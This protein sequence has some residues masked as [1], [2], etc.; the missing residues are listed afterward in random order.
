MMLE[1]R[2][3]LNT[4]CSAFQLCSQ[5]PS[6]V[7]TEIINKVTDFAVTGLRTLVFGIRRVE[8]GRYQELLLELARAQCQWG[9]GGARAV[10]AA[11][12]NIET[13]NQLV[14][15]SAVEDKLQ[16]GVRKCLRSLISAGIQVSPAIKL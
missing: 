1:M 7:R 9:A 4:N 13:D 12:A 16:R 15:V 10:A 11:H 8:P 3:I 5:T 14:G 6:D 2:Q